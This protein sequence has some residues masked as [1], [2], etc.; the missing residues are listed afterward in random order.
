[1]RSEPAR[2]CA[3]SDS[4]QILK[5]QTGGD[6]IG[7]GAISISATATMRAVLASARYA[8]RGAAATL[9][10]PNISCLQGFAC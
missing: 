5:L 9:R 8:P 4:W 6:T 1:M 10:D 2:R 3:G 7:L